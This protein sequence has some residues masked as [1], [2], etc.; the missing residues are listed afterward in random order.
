MTSA[1]GTATTIAAPDTAGNYKLCLVNSSGGDS[2][3]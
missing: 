1:E 2:Q 3:I